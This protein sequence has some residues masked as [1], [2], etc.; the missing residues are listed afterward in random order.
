MLPRQDSLPPHTSPK[1]GII[2][3]A[4]LSEP[5]IDS[6]LTLIDKVDLLFNG[7]TTLTHTLVYIQYS[8]IIN[9]NNTAIKVQVNCVNS[10]L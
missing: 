1:K 3:G 8:F 2:I 4:S 6:V 7:E 5:H 9:V 10:E